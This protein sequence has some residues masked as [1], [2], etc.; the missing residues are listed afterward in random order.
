MENFKG[1]EKNKF[2]NI[3]RINKNATV[4]DLQLQRSWLY[5]QVDEIEKRSEPVYN[6][7]VSYKLETWAKH[8][9]RVLGTWFL[10]ILSALYS[11]CPL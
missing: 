8:S 1:S 5:E 3:S 9:S 11:L 2:E 10:C 4:D 7:M 6:L